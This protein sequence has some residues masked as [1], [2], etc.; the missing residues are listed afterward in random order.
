MNLIPKLNRDQEVSLKILNRVNADELSYSLKSCHPKF[1][2]AWFE[3]QD[4]EIVV[5]SQKGFLVLTPTEK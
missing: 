5:E 1:T 2:D 3:A 4:D